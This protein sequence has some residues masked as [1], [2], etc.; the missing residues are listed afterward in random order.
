MLSKSKAMEKFVHEGLRSR[1]RESSRQ[2]GREFMQS[3]LV[4]KRLRRLECPLQ[5]SGRSSGG[6]DKGRPRTLFRSGAVR[7]PRVL[8]SGAQV[9]ANVQLQ[10]VTQRWAAQ[11]WVMQRP[12]PQLASELQDRPALVP[13]EHVLPQEVSLLQ[14]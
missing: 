14:D 1:M 2:L 9:S 6:N 12:P 5:A 11:R 13:P 3:R 4:L 7:A 8:C 10:Y